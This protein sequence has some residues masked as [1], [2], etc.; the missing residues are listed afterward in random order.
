MHTAS[1]VE[2]QVWFDVTC[3]L[4]RG[5]SPFLGWVELGWTRLDWIG[6]KNYNFFWVGLG[7]AVTTCG[8]KSQVFIAILLTAF[9]QR[10]IVDSLCYSKNFD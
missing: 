4:G 9:C 1:E 5:L 2:G 3:R 7:Q 6:L 8:E 10:L